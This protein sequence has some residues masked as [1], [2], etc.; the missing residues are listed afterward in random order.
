MEQCIKLTN[1][2]VNSAIHAK[3][4]FVL[5]KELNAIIFVK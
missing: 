4:A 1:K 3:S 5:H 2:S